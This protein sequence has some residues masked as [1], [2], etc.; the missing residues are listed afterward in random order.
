MKRYETTTI[1]QIKE[2]F[3]HYK[4]I[5]RHLKI[6]RRN[7]INFDEIDVRVGCIRGEEIL[8]PADIKQYYVVSPKNRKSIS[9]DYYAYYEE[10]AKR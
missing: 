8:M 7:V 1:K 4:N 5:L 6:R 3:E 9:V 2:W 10:F